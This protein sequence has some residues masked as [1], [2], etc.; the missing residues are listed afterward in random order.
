M[1]EGD[2]TSCCVRIVFLHVKDFLKFIVN[3]FSTLKSKL[4]KIKFKTSVRTAK[5]THYTITKFN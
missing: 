3:P 1:Q 4:I 2:M 5:K